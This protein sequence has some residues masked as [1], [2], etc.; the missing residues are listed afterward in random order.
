MHASSSPNAQQYPVEQHLATTTPSSGTTPSN[1]TSAEAA[2]GAFHLL[3]YSCYSNLTHMH[4]N[5]EQQMQSNEASEANSFKR[6]VICM[7]L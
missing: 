6:A 7:I 3:L 5:S 2:G 4:A 1:A